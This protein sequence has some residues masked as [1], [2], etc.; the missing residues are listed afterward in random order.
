MASVMAVVLVLGAGIGLWAIGRSGPISLYDRGGAHRLDANASAA[1]AKAVDAVVDV[2]VRLRAL[3]R[4]PTPE[5]AGS[6]MILTSS[7]QVLTNNHVIRGATSINVTVPELGRTFTASVVGADPAD[8]VALLQLQGASGL[9]TVTIGDSSA[10]SVGDSVLAIG[11]AFGRGGTPTITSGT[12]SALNRSITVSDPTGTPTRFTG[13]IETDA[14]V[15]PG[16]SGG[17]L[18][19]STGQVV[20]MIAAGPSGAEGRPAPNIG[21]AI[22]TNHAIDIVGE[23]R[24][25]HGSSTILLGERG[26]LG[27]SVEQLDLATAARL[28]L[29]DASGVL[30][31]GVEPGSPADGAGMTAG[32]VIESIDGRPIPTIDALGQAIHVHAPGEQIRVTWVDTGGTHSATVQLVSGPAV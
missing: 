20:G 32:S 22:P 1:A 23:I 15:R 11:N 3:G 9:P 2:N 17:P 18:V 27:I 7:G 31:A 5:G 10:L 29:N 28:G 4:G 24:A 6:G 14:A 16:D 26:F 13:L 8:D 21:F 25:G 19:N 30:V 12:I